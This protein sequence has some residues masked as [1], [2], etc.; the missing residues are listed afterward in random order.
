RME[1]RDSDGAGARKVGYFPQLSGPP[2][3]L[4]AR[5]SM[6]DPPRLRQQNPA[7][8]PEIAAPAQAAG[9]AIIPGNP[10]PFHEFHRAVRAAAARRRASTLPIPGP[11]PI[12]LRPAPTP[13]RRTLSS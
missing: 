5:R 13:D 1:I 11:T 12:R 4:Q 3:L 2:G 6:D 10:F 9:E 7:P 8:R